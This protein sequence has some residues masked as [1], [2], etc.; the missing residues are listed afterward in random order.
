MRQI[1]PLEY[2]S[3]LHKQYLWCNKG[4]PALQLEWKRSILVHVGHAA[5]DSHQ[6][7]RSFFEARPLPTLAPAGAV[8]PGYDGLYLLQRAELRN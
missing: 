1:F 8:H 3:M 6:N 5:I 2:F 4:A 7:S